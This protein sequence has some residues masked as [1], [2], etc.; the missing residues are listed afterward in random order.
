MKLQSLLVS[1]TAI[2]WF[3]SY[4]TQRSQVT[5]VG[6][7]VSESLPVTVGVPQESILGPLLFIIYINDLPLSLKHY[8][9][10]LY[11]DDSVIYC[12]DTS[13]DNMQSRLNEDLQ[14]LTQ[15][16]CTNKLSINVS[17]CKLMLLGHSSRLG[18]FSSLSLSISGKDFEWMMMMM[19]NEWW[20]VL[21]F[22]TCSQGLNCR[23]TRE[24]RSDVSILKAPLAA[25]S[26][27]CDHT[28][29][30][31]TYDGTNRDRPQHRALRALLFANSAC[32]LLR[33]TIYFVI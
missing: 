23:G 10:P 25:A 7:A 22:L 12:S 19:M 24:V 11:A 21:I 8:K 28:S 14:R 9:V 20:M 6:T 32:V 5:K 13:P 17:K 16:F 2:S 1:P 3:T 15:W 31:Q 30:T 26:V 27:H 4:P 18:D 29:P 33:P